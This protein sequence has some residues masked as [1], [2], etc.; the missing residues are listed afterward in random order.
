MLL[1]LLYLLYVPSD[2]RRSHFTRNPW[3]CPRVRKTTQ[4]FYYSYFKA[5]E[6]QRQQSHHTVLWI[7]GQASMHLVKEAHQG[8]GSCHCYFSETCLSLPPRSTE[9]ACASMWK[10]LSL[11]THVKC[12]ER[13]W[14]SKS[15]ITGDAAAHIKGKGT[16]QGLYSQLGQLETLVCL[17][18]NYRPLFFKLFSV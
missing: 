5:F 13:T 14:R 12:L 1:S 6:A 10:P 4:C 2:L 16:C 7:E 18:L 9:Q 8:S 15:A 3:L 11:P 17:S